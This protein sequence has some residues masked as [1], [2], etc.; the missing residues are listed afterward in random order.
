VNSPRCSPDANASLEFAQILLWADGL[1]KTG[2]FWNECKGDDHRIA[3]PG[4]AGVELK[5]IIPS[6]RVV[7]E[8]IQRILRDDQTV[9]GHFDDNE[10]S[11]ALEFTYANRTIILGGDGTEKNWL[12]RRRFETNAGKGLS[13]DVVN[14]PHHG[15]QNGCSPGVLTQLFAD[16][17]QRFAVTSADGQSHPDLDVIKWLQAESISP[18]C[19]NLIPACGAN[20]QQLLSLPTLDPEIARWVREV[21]TGAKTIQPCQGDVKIEINSAGAIFIEPEHNN[22]CAFRGDYDLLFGLA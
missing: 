5:T 2:Q 14:L 19:T 13:A 12:A 21:S 6:A 3:P 22:A 18:Y 8:Y 20:A 10:I 17:G 9:L 16:A 15:S 4:F 11:L 1:Q 7:G